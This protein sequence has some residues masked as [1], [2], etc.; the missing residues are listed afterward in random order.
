[1]LSRGEASA[2]AVEQAEQAQTV[3]GGAAG[4]RVAAGGRG[5]RVGRRGAE[6][7][8]VL[9]LVAEHER[10]FADGQF[11]EERDAAKVRAQ[12]R[13]GAREAGQK[14]AQRFGQRWPASIHR[15]TI[16]EDCGV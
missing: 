10:D 7:Q 2:A 1:M 14:A 3:E 11:I 6:W 4:R 12:C 15:A 13:S 8:D 9:E 5:A 16:R